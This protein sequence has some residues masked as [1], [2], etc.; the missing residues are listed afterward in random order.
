ML[1]L[2][3]NK[4]KEFFYKEST[5]DL[6]DRIE[7]ESRESIGIELAL[8][9]EMQEEIEKEDS[10]ES[11]SLLVRASMPR[12]KKESR[13]SLITTHPEYYKSSN[14]RKYRHSGKSNYKNK[15][16]HYKSRKSSMRVD[17]IYNDYLEEIN[18][19]SFELN[20]IIV[21]Q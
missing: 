11:K 12:N 17:D 4:I 20:I 19:W 10:K 16:A 21:K 3:I 5:E 9:D 1:Q 8:L 15:S 7:R 2:I 13:K 6:I 14:S 18:I